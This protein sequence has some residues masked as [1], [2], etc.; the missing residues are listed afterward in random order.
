MLKS[1][2]D[3][4]VDDVDSFIK[5]WRLD[6]NKVVQDYDSLKLNNLSELYPNEY[7]NIQKWRLEVNMHS[8]YIKSL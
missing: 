3:T 4:N 2:Y 6:I 1:W 8:N 7:P 5:K